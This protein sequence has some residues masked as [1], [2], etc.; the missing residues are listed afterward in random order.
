MITAQN[1]QLAYTKRLNRVQGSNLI[2]L[3]S[4]TRMR[5]PLK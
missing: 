5:V 4:R 1:Q 2:P 3:F